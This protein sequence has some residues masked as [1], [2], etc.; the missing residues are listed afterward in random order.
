MRIGRLEIGKWSTHKDAPMVWVEYLSGKNSCGCTIVTICNV[1]FTWLNNECY[2][3]AL[4]RY[5]KALKRVANIC[6]IREELRSTRAK[7]T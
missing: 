2:G 7:S 5:G 1:Y 3:A 6:R 4:E